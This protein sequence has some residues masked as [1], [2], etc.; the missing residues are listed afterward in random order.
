VTLAGLH[1][2][3][4]IPATSG[5][6]SPAT[7]V[8]STG[9]PFTHAVVQVAQGATLLPSNAVFQVKD[10][11]GNVL[12]TASGLGPVQVPVPTVPATPS[13]PLSATVSLNGVFVDY[14]ATL[15]FTVS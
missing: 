12:G 14:S 3:G 10:A 2:L 9:A 8:S 7:F 13:L 11:S 15:T 5:A 6:C 1:G 4:P